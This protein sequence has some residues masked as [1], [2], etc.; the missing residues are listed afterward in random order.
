MPINEN[1]ARLLKQPFGTLVP[2][3][4]VTKRKVAS[5]LKGVKQVIAVGDATTER[6]VSFGIKPDIAVI[7]GKERRSKRSYSASY[8]AKELHCINPAG[9]ISKEAVQVLQDALRMPSPVR[10]LVD[11]EEDMLALPLF[12]MAPEGSAVLYGQPLEGLVIVKITSAKQKQAKDLM[13]R[14]GID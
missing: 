6:L 11:G 10:V 14:I 12:T 3:K 7:D 9:T 2:D 8:S 13:D 1:D 5:V 4:Q